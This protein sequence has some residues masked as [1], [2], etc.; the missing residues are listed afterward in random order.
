MKNEETI[1][2]VLKAAKKRNKQN[3]LGHEILLTDSE[4]KCIIKVNQCLQN[5]RM[6]LNGT[7]KKLKIKKRGFLNNFVDHQ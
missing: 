6:I 3:T 1:I 4:I 7:T 2:F 5:R